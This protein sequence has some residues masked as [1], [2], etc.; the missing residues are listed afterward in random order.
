[1]FFIDGISIIKLLFKKISNEL[2]LSTMSAIPM[3]GFY[4]NSFDFSE[5][6]S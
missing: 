2:S 3:L 6:I 4:K 5:I 1:M